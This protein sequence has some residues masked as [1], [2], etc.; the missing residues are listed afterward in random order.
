[1]KDNEIRLGEPEKAILRDLKEAVKIVDKTAD[2][3][4]TAELEREVRRRIEKTQKRNS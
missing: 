1:M 2:D 3:P 4:D